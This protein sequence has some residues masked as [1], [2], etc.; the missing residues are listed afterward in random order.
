MTKRI[1]LNLGNIDSIFL[2]DESLLEPIVSKGI[3]WVLRRERRSN[4]PDLSDHNNTPLGEHYQAKVRRKGANENL[5]AV[6]V[7]IN[8][9]NSHANINSIDNSVNSMNITFNTI[10]E[11]L[12]EID[13]EDTRIKAQSCLDELEASVN[14]ESFKDK[15]V[16]F[17]NI[18]SLHMTLICPFIPFLTSFI[19]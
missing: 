10:R 3:R 13:E 16:E 7:N 5:H 6:T 4:P 15:Y 2:L 19:I 9:D 18:A 14:T 8:G 11:K 12:D 17:I 1:I